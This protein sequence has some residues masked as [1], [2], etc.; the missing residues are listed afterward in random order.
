MSLFSPHFIFGK[1]HHDPLVCIADTMEEALAIVKSRCHFFEKLN[2]NK[3]RVF[4]IRGNSTSA[5]PW[6][7]GI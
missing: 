6:C 7:G 3:W 1:K 4:P 2:T 5:E